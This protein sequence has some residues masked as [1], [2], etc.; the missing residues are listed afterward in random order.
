MTTKNK[1]SGAGLIHQPIPDMADTLPRPNIYCPRHGYSGPAEC[2][3]CAA[4]ICE[5]CN[6][7]PSTE[8]WG[9]EN[10]ALSLARNPRLTK[11]WCK[12]CVLVAQIAY[13]KR[14]TPIDKLERELA[15]L[16]QIGSDSVSAAEH[17][18]A[19]GR[20]AAQTT[21]S[22]SGVPSRRVGEP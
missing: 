14:L 5:N 12:R 22:P 1:D 17:V 21:L 11:R 13:A 7:A 3:Y 20:S 18:A 10:D 8:N 2:P 19:S 16:D 9:G 6:V 15:A 4:I